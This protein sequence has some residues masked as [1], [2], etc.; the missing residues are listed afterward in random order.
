[1]PNRIV[2]DPS[3]SCPFFSFSRDNG[4]M[5]GFPRFEC[6]QCGGDLGGVS[7][8]A[9]PA[10]G[11]DIGMA[12]VH[13]RGTLRHWRFLRSRRWI[14]SIGILAWL[15]AFAGGCWVL[16]FAP[17]VGFVVL[18]ATSGLGVVGLGRYLTIRKEKKN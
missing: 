10:C 17:G 8:N 4:G 16:S 2:R 3:F 18:T 14:E 12:R 11:Y 6:P 1:M 13:R 5:D 7:S 15:G 9:C